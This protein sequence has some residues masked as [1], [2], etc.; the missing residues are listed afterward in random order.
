MAMG[1]AGGYV[2]QPAAVLMEH[3]SWRA[4][5]TVHPPARILLRLA[6]LPINLFSIEARREGRAFKLSLQTTPS[7]L[8]YLAVW[9][10]RST[11][12]MYNT[13]WNIT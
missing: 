3:L 5:G 11:Q 6:I 7:I 1:G 9:S 10:L 8:L 2:P 12:S 4:F 13:S